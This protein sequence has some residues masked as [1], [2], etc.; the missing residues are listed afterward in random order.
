[1]VS[2]P[3]IATSASANAHP[4]SRPSRRTLVG[5]GLKDKRS[6]VKPL[7]S[8]I[9]AHIAHIPASAKSF[10]PSSNSLQ[11]DNGETVKYDYLIVAAGLQISECSRFDRVMLFTLDGQLS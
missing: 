2:I 5:A 7:D 4:T 8:L 1:M 10:S 11:L 9:P 3:N 6:F